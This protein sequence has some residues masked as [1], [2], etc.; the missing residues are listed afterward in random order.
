MVSGTP[1][2]RPE[3]CAVAQIK[4]GDNL[5]AEFGGGKSPYQY[6]IPLPA[7]NT[8]TKPELRDHQDPKYPDF[9]V[10]Y[11]DQFRADEFLR[12]FAGFVQAKKS[13]HGTRASEFLSGALAQRSHRRNQARLAHAKRRCGG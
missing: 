2:G 11:P 12:E 9:K 4:P 10:E 8:P 5:P 13:G 7:Q 6:A 1:T 3:K